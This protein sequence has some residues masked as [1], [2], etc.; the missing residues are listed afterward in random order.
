MVNYIYLW[1]SNE[2]GGKAGL[3]NSTLI[4]FIKCLL[5]TL[6]HIELRWFSATVAVFYVHLPAHKTAPGCLSACLRWLFIFLSSISNCS[7]TPFVSPHLRSAVFIFHF[8]LKCC[9]VSMPQLCIPP[10]TQTHSHTHSISVLSLQLSAFPFLP[11]LPSADHVLITPQRNALPPHTAHLFWCSPLC[12][13]S[14]RHFFVLTSI[15]LISFL[16]L[17]PN[18]S[19][20]LSLSFHNTRHSSGK[21]LFPCFS[22]KCHTLQ[23]WD[24]N[25]GK[26]EQ[27]PR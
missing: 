24:H 1:R 19:L 16:L 14:G 11:A 27:K 12:P 20:R 9:P 10:N 25:V 2:L 13:I 23:Q 17:C 8:L 21:L 4:D 6:K 22:Q 26:L 5:F 18:Y 15:P 3:I 7:S